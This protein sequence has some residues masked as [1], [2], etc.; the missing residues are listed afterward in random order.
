[1]AQT[2]ALR[3]PHTGMV[4]INDITGNPGDIHPRNKQDVGR[5]LALK[6]M[7]QVYGKA[8]LVHSGPM[9]R[10]ATAEGGTIRV[11]F[12]HAAGGLKTSDGRAPSHLEVAGADG[13]FVPATGAIEGDSLVVRSD[14]V[15]QPVAVRYGWHESAMP[16]LQNREGLP[17][18]P[19]HSGKWP[20]P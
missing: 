14:A 10:Q 7:A 17:A 5:R 4:V 15:A 16:N 6:A 18:A 2:A 8:D 11:R 20:L 19:F 9:F 12:D 1:M 3:Q 13:T